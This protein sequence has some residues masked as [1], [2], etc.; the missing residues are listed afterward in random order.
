MRMELLCCLRMVNMV[1][2]M[3]NRHGAVV[4]FA[5]CRWINCFVKAGFHWSHF[6]AFHPR[7]SI[8]TIVKWYANRES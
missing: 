6:I 2:G 5:N 8:I 4:L 1:V 7:M 3:V